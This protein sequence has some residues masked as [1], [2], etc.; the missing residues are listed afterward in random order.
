MPGTEIE[1]GT[2]TVLVIEDEDVV[3]DVNRTMLRKLGYRVLEA[4]TGR[5]AIDIAGSFDRDIDLVLLDIQL[6]DME[7]KKLYDLIKETRPNLKVIVCSGYSLDGPAQ[8]ILDAGAQ[9]FIQKPFSISFL[10]KKLKDC[11]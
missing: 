10:S 7:S 2:G 8:E 6:P 3:M 1:L 11:F 9:D 5:E 4:K